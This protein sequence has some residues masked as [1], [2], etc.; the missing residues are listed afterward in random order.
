ML[1][2]SIGRH[3]S[4]Y[5]LL[6]AAF[7][8]PNA[9]RF[10]KRLATARLTQGGSAEEIFRWPSDGK[11]IFTGCKP[12]WISCILGFLPLLKPS[13]HTQLAASWVPV[14]PT[15]L[16]FHSTRGSF[17]RMTKDLWGQPWFGMKISPQTVGNAWL[18]EMLYHCITLWLWLTVCH[19]KSPF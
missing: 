12:W 6:L 8:H 2:G 18:L 16:S 14:H 3:T 4:Y 10:A 19:G 11:W 7:F 9:V 15:Q 17:T 1:G 5:T 13:S